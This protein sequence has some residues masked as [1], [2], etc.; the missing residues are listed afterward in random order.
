MFGLYM[1]ILFIIARVISIILD[2]KNEIDWR[3]KAREN[4]DALWV[5]RYGTA[6][7]TNNDKPFMMV[8]D[9]KTGDLLEKD[10]YTNEII[11]NDSADYRYAKLTEAKQKGNRVYTYE[12]ITE[13]FTLNSRNHKDDKYWIQGRRWIDVN[14]GRT[15][16]RRCIKKMGYTI[17]YLDI[18][19]GLY[20]FP[21]DEYLTDN[22]E[23]MC[24]YNG[25][26]INHKYNENVISETLAYL[27][28]QQIQKIE[29][30]G[31]ETTINGIRV[32]HND[33]VM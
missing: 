21:D 5:D 20:A 22:K 24:F 17:W 31:L 11:R 7:H 14:T 19:T 8:R 2:R 3:N 1:L 9:L 29:E 13:D 10:P 33:E 12:R 16:V 26:L 25:S 18:E 23:H 28:K 4:K 30:V 15:Y 32:W 27:N 6:H